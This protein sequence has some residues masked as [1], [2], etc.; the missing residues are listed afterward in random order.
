MVLPRNVKIRVAPVAKAVDGISTDVV[1]SWIDDKGLEV[2]WHLDRR[3]RSELVVG[4]Q[5]WN[6]CPIQGKVLLYLLKWEEVGNP[7]CKAECQVELEW[8]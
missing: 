8:M 4:G 3:I 6:H 5:P 2:D 7:R 1:S